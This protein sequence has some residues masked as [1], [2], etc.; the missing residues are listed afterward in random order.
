MKEGNGR[1]NLTFKKRVIFLFIMISL[2]IFLLIGRVGYI[3]LVK[4]AE[5]QKLAVE[6][7]TNDVKIDAKRGKIF[8]RNGNEL[9]I[10]A[11]CERVDA[12]MK[13]IIKS[14]IEDPDIKAK[15]AS[16][17]AK[18]LGDKEEDILKKLNMTLSNGKPM[19]SVNIK[20]RIEKSQADEIRKLKLPGII[21]SEDSKRYY[22]NGSFLSNVL[23]F[24]NVDGV[25]QEGIELKYDSELRGTPGRSIMEADL[26][27]RELPYNISKY[28][29][30]VA[31]NDIT[32]TIDENI[33]FYVEK[34][35]EDALLVNKA[36]A[37][38]AIVMDPTNGEVLAMANKPDFNPN[39]PRDMSGHTDFQDVIKSWSNR[40]VTYTYEP[41]SIFKVI[42]AA[43]A[44][45]EGVVSD[46][47]RF[48]CTGSMIVGDRRIKCWRTKG[49]GTQDFAQ[50]LQNSCNIGFMTL[51]ERLG[52]EKMYKYIEAFGFGTPTNIDVTFEEGGYKRPV[53]KMGPVEL[54]NLSFGQ[55]ITVT[56][57]Q[58]A[59]V[60]SIIANDGKMMEPH[61][62]KKI[63][64]VDK[65]GNIIEKKETQPKMV[66]QVISPE[67]AKQLRGY[68]EK[69]ISV[70]GGKKAYV[71]GYS[72]AGKTGTAQKAEGGR[73]ASGK[74]VASFVGMAPADNPKYVVYVSIDEPDPSNYYAGQIAA[75]L[76]GQIF[77]D[78]FVNANMKPDNSL[79]PVIEVVIPNVIG[80][81]V[82]EAVNNL[83]NSGF[84]VEVKD[85]GT[86]VID[87]NPLA[88]ISV[89]SGSKVIL[90][91]GNG[92]NYNNKVIVPNLNGMSPKEASEVLSSLDLKLKA[93]GDGYVT[94]QE[95]QVGEEVTTGSTID[96]YFD[97]YGD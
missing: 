65:D 10:S 31:G 58:M 59:T 96:A 35:I 49:H 33:Q 44:L 64:S 38:T 79:K 15:I 37:V 87:M 5:L 48:T 23:G 52:K 36:K 60:F 80:L 88:G 70:G 17:L 95:P 67:V 53:S 69:V 4:G 55:G 83:K 27:R 68:L 90:Y 16:E 45:S 21:V 75:P 40:S 3:Q 1:T 63:Q 14:Q 24:T 73:Y 46:K 22:P 26:V 62:V 86:T 50:I 78:I 56:P 76:A 32:L 54:A 71:E 29:E 94:E 97:I 61:L 72:I 57:I 11:N 47:D 91:T 19:N 43:A 92:Q 9:A 82:R 84:E 8:D 85:K 34:A 7:W 41:G 81:P 13:D 51:G 18:I 66:R 12:Y 28:I 89:V 42:T 74:Y 6:Q 30:P 77:K 93:I 20:R 2:L 25:G 39:T